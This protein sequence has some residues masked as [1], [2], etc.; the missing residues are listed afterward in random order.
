MA[1]ETPKPEKRK[2]VAVPEPSPEKEEPK[3]AL[4]AHQIREAKKAQLV[5][6]AEE[7]GLSAEGK[8]DE[9]RKRLLARIEKETKAEKPPEEAAPPKAE[10][11]PAR[12]ER[13]LAA[14]PKKKPEKEEAEEEPEYVAKAKPTLDP[15]L[16]RLLSLRAAKTAARPKFRRQEWFRYRRLGDKWRRPDGGQSKLRRRFGYRWNVPSIGYRGPREVRG[17][18]PSGFQEVLVHNVRQLDGLD[19]KKQ[20][21]RVAHA[22]GTRKREL[23][24]QAC[25][26]KGLRVLNRM[27]TE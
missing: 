4:T 26:D 24:E 9:L 12:R 14:K 7:R 27:V 13:K 19:P 25:D 17:L 16:E 20:A 5:E 11:K 10:K 8:V 18:H 23:I 21:V 2:K 3:A 1:D 6:W 15:R 22:V